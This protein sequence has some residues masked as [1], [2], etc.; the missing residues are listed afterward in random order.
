MAESKK[1]KR[2]TVQFIAEL[3]EKNKHDLTIL[4]EYTGI[5]EPIFYR[6]NVCGQESSKTAHALLKGGGCSFCTGREIRKGYNTFGDLYPDIVKY[7]DD[8]EEAYKHSA[9]SKKKAKLKCPICFQTYEIE[10]YR[11]KK[12]GFHCSFCNK[13]TY[14]NKFLRVLLQEL[15]E[16]TD[17]EFEK[18]FSIDKQLIRY[19]GFFHYQ[20]K[21]FI[22]EMNGG[23]HYYSCSFNNG[24]VKNQQNKD[25]FKEVFAKK[26]NYIFIPINCKIS[27]FNYIKQNICDSILK[28]YFD[29][30]HLNWI[31][32]Y[33]QINDYSLLNQLCSDYENNYITVK[34]LSQ[35]YQIDRHIVIRMLKLGA[36]LGLCSTYLKEE[37]ARK[38]G[39]KTIAYDDKHNYIGTYPSAAFCAKELNERYNLDFRANSIS[40]VLA[41]AQKTH[42]NFYFERGE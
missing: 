1:L 19:D 9:G 22:I 38:V 29:L 35:K 16:I 18:T 40:H 25:S 11:L 5:E 37:K 2:T 27:D 32:M 8:P 41:G 24:D 14:P 13:M 10:F 21:I 42:R 39:V 3:K 15:P 34:E 36:S 20:D 28:E 6:C 31:K 12:T 30:K 33:Q 17:V 4:S 23:Q 7:F 26:N